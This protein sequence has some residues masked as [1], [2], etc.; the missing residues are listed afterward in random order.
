MG[1][2]APW[3]RLCLLVADDDRD[4]LARLR[5][6]IAEALSDADVVWTT[7]MASV[8]RHLTWLRPDCVLLD[9]GL[10]D[11]RGLAGLDRMTAAAP[12]VPVI[13]LTAS[14][15]VDFGILAVASGAQDFLVKRRT[16][17]DSL[18]RALMYS[19]ERKR[20]ELAAL[21]LESIRLNADENS[22]LERGLQPTPLLLPAPGV[23]VV[24]S[25]RPSRAG[26]LLGGDFYDVVQTPDRVTHV[27]IGDVSGHGPEAAALGVA[28]RIAWRTLVASGVHGADVMPRL[29][30]LLRAERDGPSSFAT[31]L[32]LSIQ[33]DGSV[34]AVCAGHPGML[35]HG[36]SDVHWVE[37]RR[38]PALGLGGAG[39]PVESFTLPDGVGLILLTD[40]LFE[41]HSGSGNDRLGEDGLLEIARALSALEAGDFVEALIGGAERRAS[42]HGGLTD[43]VAVVRIARSADL[44]A[45]RPA[46]FGAAR[47]GY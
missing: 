17:A 19:I 25:Y 13:A 9:L 46:G 37:P 10:P 26:T 40:G 5:G 32:S 20:G 38:G 18:R 4:S 45:A 21:E 14:E 1:P 23:D 27:V 2:V 41:G 24:T 33:P 28:L 16:D 30:W 43:D 12:S 44:I 29:E 47:G 39:W 31:A 11:G 8:E 7:S 34:D 15:D 22:R 35:W 6:L 36:T 42:Q 3:H